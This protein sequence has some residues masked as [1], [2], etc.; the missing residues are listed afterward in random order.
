MA[1][2]INPAVV[3]AVAS[4]IPALSLIAYLV[5]LWG[6]LVVAG[7]VIGLV[8]NLVRLFDRAGIFAVGPRSLDRL[9]SRG[10]TCGWT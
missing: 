8:I 4:I 10:T 7:V 3:R 9:T 5:A 6:V 2:R 1:D